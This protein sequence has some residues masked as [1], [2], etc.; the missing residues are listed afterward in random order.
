V[1]AP[2]MYRNEEGNVKAGR[3][4]VG[5]LKRKHL[6]DERVIVMVLLLVVLYTTQYTKYVV[7]SYSTTNQLFFLNTRNLKLC[8]TLYE[9]NRTNNST[10]QHW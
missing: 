10:H 4:T 8:S 2:D 5:K 9:C 6:E 1:Q 3:V 7:A